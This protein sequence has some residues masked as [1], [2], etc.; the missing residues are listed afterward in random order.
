[1][2]YDGGTLEHVF[3]LPVALTNICR[4]LKI[5]GRIIHDSP[6]SGYL[7]HGFTSLQPTLFYDFYRAQIFEIND[8]Q[9]S[10]MSLGSVFTEV[11]HHS[12][13]VPGMYDF[14][15]TWAIE[16]YVY[17]TFCAATKREVFQE[18]RIPQQSIWLR[19][20]GS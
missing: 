19:A 2:V 10:K 9:V 15:K 5:D 20:S 12:S 11:G 16:Q 7:D 18:M 6:T 14:E 4:L 17:M 1:M 8:I 3:N 13:Y